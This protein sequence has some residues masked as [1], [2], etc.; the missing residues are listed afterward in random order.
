[1][2]YQHQETP[3]LV[4]SEVYSI[5]FIGIKAFEAYRNLN[6]AHRAIAEWNLSYTFDEI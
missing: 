2:S 3:I 6:V 1:M 5:S 4:V